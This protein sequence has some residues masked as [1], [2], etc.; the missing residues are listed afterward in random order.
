MLK[1]KDYST[2]I[3]EQ[4]KEYESFTKDK[5]FFAFTEEQFNEGMKRFGLAPMIPTRFIKS[6]SEDIS[7]VPR[8]RLIMI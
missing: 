5:M 2:L 7:F 1:Y 3:N 6:A 4:Q 8:L